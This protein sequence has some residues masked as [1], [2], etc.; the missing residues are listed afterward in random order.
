MDQI[1]QLARL[2]TAA[3]EWPSSVASSVWLAVIAGWPFA[4]AGATSTRQCDIVDGVT[5]SSCEIRGWAVRAGRLFV[6]DVLEVSCVVAE[7]GAAALKS[8]CN[9]ACVRPEVDSVIDHEV[10]AQVRQR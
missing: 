9:Y 4:T 8:L 10:K 2:S 1:L 7:E 6:E 3:D 5:V